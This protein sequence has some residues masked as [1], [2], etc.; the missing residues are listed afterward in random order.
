MKT[1]IIFLSLMLGLVVTACKKETETPTN[2][3]ANTTSNS[4]LVITQLNDTVDF[5]TTSSCSDWSVGMDFDSIHT[6]LYSPADY[7]IQSKDSNC[8]FGNN[9][10]LTF[11][12]SNNN[13]LFLDDN[14]GGSVKKYNVGDIVDYNRVANSGSSSMGVS[15]RILEQGVTTSFNLNETFYLGLAFL[16]NGSYYNG[17][18][19]VKTLNNYHSCIVI[20]YAVNKTA[21]TP[22][23][24]Q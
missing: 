13:K 12:A 1:K 19:K 14:L 11:S 5:S 23:T 7:K 16:K 21:N 18:V 3:T 6:D 22:I 20:E 15:A 10:D 9:L 4:N 17:W 24:I 8:V 2:E